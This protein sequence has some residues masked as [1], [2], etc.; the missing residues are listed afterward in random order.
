MS[1]SRRLTS[2]GMA[3]STMRSYIGYYAS[4]RIAACPSICARLF[5][6]R[7]YRPQVLPFSGSYTGPAIAKPKA[8]PP[9]SRDAASRSGPGIALLLIACRRFRRTRGRQCCA[10]Y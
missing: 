10:A 5:M 2:T 4:A 9:R 7:I 1:S 8:T 3:I 6:V